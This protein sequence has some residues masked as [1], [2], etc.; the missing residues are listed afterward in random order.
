MPNCWCPLMTYKDEKLSRANVHMMG[1]FV[2]FI[3]M[4]MCILGSCRD[5]LSNEIYFTPPGLFISLFLNFS[6]TRRKCSRTS[7]TCSNWIKSHFDTDAKRWKSQ[8]KNVLIFRVR[9]GGSTLGFLFFFKIP[10]SHKYSCRR[11]KLSLYE[12]S[13]VVNIC[14]CRYMDILNLRSGDF[15]FGRLFLS[16]ITAVVIYLYKSLQNKN[17]KTK[18]CG[19]ICSS[20]VN[21]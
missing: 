14:P 15:F 21:A 9:V 17:L 12:A 10:L 20:D 13:Y 11:T 1:K 7:S 16:I 4:S 2:M 18:L 5:W 8:R 19:V 6:L 3:L